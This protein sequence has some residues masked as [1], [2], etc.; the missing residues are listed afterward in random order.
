MI[1]HVM[2]VYGSSLQSVNYGAEWLIVRKMALTDGKQCHLLDST[3]TLAFPT[4]PH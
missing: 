1:T 3:K 4:S 2:S